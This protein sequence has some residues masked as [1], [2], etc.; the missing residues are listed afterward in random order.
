MN[1]ITYKGKIFFSLLLIIIGTVASTYQLLMVERTYTPSAIGAFLNN[2]LPERTPGTGEVTSWST[3]PA[4]RNLFFKDPLVITHHPK[5]D[6]LFVA[7]RDGLIEYFENNPNVSNKQTFADL[8]GETAVVWDGGFLGLAFHPEFGQANSPNRNYFYVYYT[9]KGD[10]GRQGPFECGQGCF[11]CFDNPSWWGSYLTL[12]RY[13]VREGT[14]Q[15]DKNSRQT[16]FKIRQFGGTH[17]GGGPIFGKDGF[18]YVAI[19][20]QARYQ[21]AQRIDNNFEGGYIR[22]DVDQK[23]GNISHPPRRRMGQQA[24]TGDETSGNGYYI[25]NDNPWQD[26]NG[27]IFEEFWAIGHRN[28]HRI[29]VDR[30]TGDIW[31][32]EIGENDREEINLVT[33]G[34][35]GGWPVWEG[36]LNISGS[37]CGVNSLGRGFYKGP[38]T[39]FTRNESNAI[40]GG[41]V[42]RGV[43]LPQLYGKYLCGD[44]SQSRIF[45]VEP[46]GNRQTLTSFSPGAMITWG[47]DLQGELYIGRQNGNTNLYQ[48]QANGTSPPAP[49]LL[50]Q[51]G[52]FTDLQNLTVRDGIIPYEM[53]E[54][55]WSDGAEKYRWVAIPNNGNHNTPEEQVTFSEDGNWQFPKGSVMIKHFEYGGRKIETRFEVH[56]QDGQY[57]YLSYRWN[58]QGTDAVLGNNSETKNFFINGENFSWYYPST[59]DCQ[60]CHQAAAGKVLGLKTRYLNKTIDYGPA[61]GQQNQLLAWSSQGIFNRN[62]SAGD[63][64]NFTTVAAK[65]DASASLEWRAR[66]YIDVN[67]SYCHLPG[68]GNRASFDARIT[69]SLDNQNLIYGFL[70]NSLGSGDAFTIVPQ[71]IPNSMIHRR[72]NS[73]TD[74]IAMPP[75]AKGRVDQA[76]VQ[77]IADWISSL[78]VGE[79]PEANGEGIGL[80]GAYYTG[81]NFN[82][83]VADRLDP[84]VDFNL[85]NAPVVGVGTE[86]FSVRWTG[87]VEAPV[88][89]TYTFFTNSDDGVRLSVNNTQLIDNFTLHGTTEDNGQITL[90]KGQRV[91]ILLEY[92]QQ[93]GG[94]VIT[95][96]WSVTGISK[97]IIPKQYL[98]PCLEQIEPITSDETVCVGESVTLSATPS[99]GGTIEWYDMPTNGNLLSTGNTFQSTVNQTTTFYV[100]ENKETSFEKGGLT[101]RDGLQ[102]VYHGNT[103]YG[104][105]FDAL[106]DFQLRSVKVYADQPGDRTVIIQNAAGTTIQSKTI[107]IPAGETRII[108]DFDIPAGQ[109]HVMKLSGDFSNLYRN[110]GAIGYPFTISDIAQIKGATTD[111]QFAFYYYFYDWEVKTNSS[112]CAYS[113]RVPVTV[114]VESC[115]TRLQAKVLLEGF[116]QG[117]AEMV[118]HARHT[119]L[120]PTQ[121]PF[122][123]G[124][125]LYNGQESAQTIPNSILDWV[126]VITR[127]GNG[128]P[129]ESYACF[130]NTNG[131][132]VGLDGQLGIPVEQSSSYFS[133]HHKSHLAVM[134]ATPYAGGVYDFTT[135][136]SQ[137]MGNAQLKEQ[138]GKYVLYCGD[139]DG[140]GN[141]NAADFN[142][143]A[144]NSAVLNQY[145]FIDGDGNGVI[146]AT[147]YNLWVRNKSKLG[148]SPLRF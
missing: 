22:I 99:N 135:S 69:T 25:P 6:L 2:R 125:W 17:R 61:L 19:G 32:G 54:P 147:D 51:T 103:A 132:L 48:L 63:I 148:H 86:N 34:S 100:Q 39:D 126:L 3:V 15:A 72:L 60:S 110:T 115:N 49:N 101:S 142:N 13:S 97:Q 146:N 113:R 82:N 108:L 46:N 81:I 130:I 47:E 43:K 27:G 121:Q 58:D 8:R 20:D 16:L 66:S 5:E 133:I 9:K 64:N 93:G 40:I 138:N 65:D 76:G 114:S 36:N 50:S 57:Y 131:E 7:S 11:S 12:E 62:I 98:Y 139:Y 73:L 112:D 120:L 4:F 78:P 88:S 137:A 83:K 90:N 71:D 10:D 85:D 42:Y 59:F 87:F 75:L 18:L 95:L 38:I 68:T 91:P 123:T 141:I 89:G 96:S 136:A 55:F 33:R 56:G 74:G 140:N 70:N 79:A 105:R 21:G 92:F 122:N 106:Q 52:A 67:C 102:G 41:N 26:G 53:I 118:Q 29:S 104:L 124:P 45:T 116:Y 128:L 31:S 30:V 129:L 145:L 111:D 84:Q 107:N 117:G 14:L 77:L 144:S 28:P 143:W 35:N 24:G 44:Y 23:G 80:N 1:R 109:D 127:D 94:Y 134:S 37:K 119:N